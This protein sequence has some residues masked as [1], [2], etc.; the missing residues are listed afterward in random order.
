MHKRIV[1]FHFRIGKSLSLTP[2]DKY[3]NETSNR[4][5]CEHIRPYC[6]NSLKAIIAHGM[7]IELS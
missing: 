5:G 7:N 3:S 4:D 1:K 2:V 6:K